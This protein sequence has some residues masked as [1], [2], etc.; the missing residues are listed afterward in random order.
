MGESSVKKDILRSR[1]D[2]ESK[3][4]LETEVGMLDG[5]AVDD[6]DE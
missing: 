6:E 5:D 1:D 4:P 2:R 3:I